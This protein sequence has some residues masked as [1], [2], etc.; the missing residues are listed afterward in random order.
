MGPFCDWETEDCS[1]ERFSITRVKR[2]L[3]HSVQSL[4]ASATCRRKDKWIT[5]TYHGSCVYSNSA[6]VFYEVQLMHTHPT[7]L[8]PLTHHVQSFKKLLEGPSKFCCSISIT[9]KKRCSTYKWKWPANFNAISYT[10]FVTHIHSIY[11]S[12]ERGRLF[13]SVA[14]RV[15]M[16]FKAGSGWKSI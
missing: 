1:W 16:W 12:A 14:S 3:F 2:A 7:T 9:W 4:Q 6:Y 15:H 11:A 5:L 8:K 10:H 13:E